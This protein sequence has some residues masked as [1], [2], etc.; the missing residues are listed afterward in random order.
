MIAA[1]ARAAR[2]LGAIRRRRSAI[3]ARRRR[4]PQFIRSH[5]WSD[6]DRRLLRRYRDGDA[7]IDAYAEDY[8]SLIYGLLELFQAD[9]DPAWLEWAI[10]LQERQDALFWDAADGGWFSTTGTDPNVLLRLKEDYDGAEPSAGSIS[11]HNLLTLGHLVGASRYLELAEQTLAR[12]GAR[13]GAAARAIPMMMAAL[14]AW[15]AAHTQIVIVGDPAAAPTRALQAEAARHYQPFAV[16]VPV[17]PGSVQALLARR[18]PFVA[19]MSAGDAGAAAYVCR[20]FTC[21]A[22][23]TTATTLADSLSR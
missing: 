6:D 1:F 14:S 8:A 18:L 13:A 11:T 19:A 7:A 22:P 12:Y 2:V 15:H 21:Q 5:L 16:V 20:E 4:R 23:V 17:T 3:V 10:V 9:G